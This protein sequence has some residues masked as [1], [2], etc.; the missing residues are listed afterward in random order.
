VR[1]N[2]LLPKTTEGRYLAVAVF[3]LVLLASMTFIILKH[4]DMAGLQPDSE[5]QTH[6]LIA[7]GCVTGCALLAS[8]LLLVAVRSAGKAEFD[9][10]VDGTSGDD[11]KKKRETEKVAVHPAVVMCHSLRR[12][13]YSRFGLFWRRKV[14]LLLVTGNEDAIEQLVPGLQKNQWLEGNR[15]VL[16]Y[17]GSLT[18][19]HDKE[20]YTALR[21]LRRGRPLD[22]IVRVLPQTLNLTPQI[23]DNDLRG[24]E[25][26]SELLR[27]S[28]PVWIWKLCDS[29]WSQTNRTEQAVGA[30]FP[31]RARTDDVTH[32]LESMLSGL[33]EQ[34]VSQ[35][36]QHRQ[37]DFLL[38]LGQSLKAGGIRRWAEQL[39]PW[40]YTTQQRITLR[41][42]MFSL[43][44]TIAK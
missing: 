9:D 23:S 32:Q 15:T 29:D 26:I 25:K 12:H 14:R 18:A 16:I 40:M 27:Y 44:Q 4:P 33:R 2:A 3:F 20:K 11:E 5:Q 42:L 10:L 39:A 38:R 17:G 24:L 31:L 35:I 34:G 8:L 37:N 22:G 21:K 19:E 1:L 41:G 6:W 28:A 7:G 30:S 13:L 43:P 36:A